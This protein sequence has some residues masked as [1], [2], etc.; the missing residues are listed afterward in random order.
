M[1]YVMPDRHFPSASQKPRFVLLNMVLALVIALVPLVTGIGGAPQP[2]AADV[3]DFTF[4]EFSAQYEL[5]RDSE[6]RSNLKTI[7]TFVAQFPDYPQNRGIIRSI[8]LDYNGVDLDTNLISVRD[9]LGNP[10]HVETTEENG[11]LVVSVGT[12]SYLLGEHHFVI[13]YTQKNVV[14]DF[15]NTNANEWYWDTN[16]LGWEQEFERASAKLR[17]SDELVPSLTGNAAC[18]QGPKGSTEKCT[19]RQHPDDPHLFEATATN[20]L[21]ANENMT[22]AVGFERGTFDVPTAPRNQWWNSALPYVLLALGIV[23][24]VMLGIARARLWRAPVGR[25]IVIPQYE[26]PSGVNLLEAKNLMETYNGA[27][28]AQLVSFAVRRNIRI[29]DQSSGEDGAGRDFALVFRTADGLDDLELR[30]ITA[31]FGEDPAP[32][33]LVQLDG[34]NETRANKVSWIMDQAKSRPLQ[35]GWKAKPEQ[36]L[37]WWWIMASWAFALSAIVSVSIVFSTGAESEMTGLAAVGGVALCGITVWICWRPTWLT[38][39]GLELRDYIEGLRMYIELAEADRFAMLQSV[40]GAERVVVEVPVPAATPSSDLKTIVHLYEQLLPYA[41][42]WN[43][44][45]SWSQALAVHY[46]AAQESPEWLQTPATQLQLDLS[47]Y[48]NTFSNSVSAAA[49][50]PAPEPSSGSSSSWTSSSSFGG[51]SFSGGSTGGGFSGGGGG[52]GGGGGR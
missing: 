47:S 48:L 50:K 15:S 40:P 29:V 12:D 8:P 3:S 41:V 26:V 35:R 5:S 20:G 27:L 45:R 17:V 2:A 7:E 21:N 31:L 9:E 1:E 39:S 13:T 24:L 49:S 23:S 18:Y 6:R 43:L 19:I 46:E 30:L 34:P 4:S 44:E 37:P 32:G 42:L 16:G 22:L 38:K 10:I 11:L 52:G 51:G 14:R 36:S 25:G 33:T 28:S